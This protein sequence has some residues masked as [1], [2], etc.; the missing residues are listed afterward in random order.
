MKMLMKS[1]IFLHCNLCFCIELKV[2]MKCRQGK[3][4]GLLQNIFIIRMSGL[5][6][7]QNDKFN[8]NTIDTALSKQTL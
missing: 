5:Q 6:V 4:Y 8:N 2:C 1:F 7:I 3:N